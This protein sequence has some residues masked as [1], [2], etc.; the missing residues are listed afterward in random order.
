VFR[1]FARLE[2]GARTASGLGLGLSIVDRIARVLN[3]SVDI[4]SQAGK[5]TRFRVEL[6]IETNVKR[7]Q[8]QPRSATGARSSD[9]L[10]LNGL[11]VLCIDN[12]PKILEGMTLLLTGMGLRSAGV[13][14]RWRQA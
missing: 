14:H 5:G 11:R 8:R 7:M 12:E 1:E 13:R 3:H 2:E 10:N 9:G 6:P 4:A